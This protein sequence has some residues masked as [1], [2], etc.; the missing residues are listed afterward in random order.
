MEKKK[1]GGE[2]KET[3]TSIDQLRQSTCAGNVDPSTWKEIIALTEGI[4][5]DKIEVSH[6]EGMVLGAK[7]E[8]FLNINNIKDLSNV[9][10]LHK[11]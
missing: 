10:G 8:A 5:E 7:A 9:I 3:V 4:G 6:Y 1:A 2:S 11:F